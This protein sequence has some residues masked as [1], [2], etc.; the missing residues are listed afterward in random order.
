M[1][2]SE[3]HEGKIMPIFSR[4]MFFLRQ[5]P[6]SGVHRFRIM[7]GFSV[8]RWVELIWFHEVLM[9]GGGNCGIII[10]LFIIFIIILIII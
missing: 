8:W 3:G 6:G 9:D 5:E 10:Y 2:E 4:M 1:C 7:S